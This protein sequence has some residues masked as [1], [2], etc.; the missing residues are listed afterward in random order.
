MSF[1]AE[2]PFFSYLEASYGIIVYAGVMQILC[3]LIL[4]AGLKVGKL[5]VNFF[6]LLK[7]SLVA[8]MIIA[9]LSHF[10]SSNLRTFVPMGA[11]GVFRGS[12]AAFFGL[13]GYDEVCVLSGESLQP[14]RTLPIAVFGTIFICTLLSVLASLALVG[15]QPWSLIDA[16]NGFSSAFAANQSPIS[17]H[18]VAVKSVFKLVNYNLEHVI[19]IDFILG[20]RSYYASFGCIGLV[21][22][23]TA[24][25][26]CDGK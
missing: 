24:S 15:M 22:S 10:Q 6:S 7:C 16:E 9:G 19:N 17:Q 25:S 23:T 12:S 1:N 5:V 14:H 8:F 4:L 13:L 2:V 21:L 18:I 11:S 20:G 26:V 3:V